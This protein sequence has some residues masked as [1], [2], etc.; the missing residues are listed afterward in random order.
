MHLENEL[1]M[2]EVRISDVRQGRVISAV[3]MHRC[4][5]NLLIAL[6]T[7]PQIR[8]C[9]VMLQLPFVTMLERRRHAA[10]EETHAA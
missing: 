7:D 5:L 8:R 3:E 1:P 6:G 4:N 10:R 2:S 9:N